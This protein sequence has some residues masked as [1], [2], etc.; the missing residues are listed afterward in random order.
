MGE[1]CPGGHLGEATTRVDTGVLLE[2]KKH[3]AAPQQGH[4]DAPAAQQLA[5]AQNE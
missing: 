4:G 1:G 3:Q 5:G 2:D